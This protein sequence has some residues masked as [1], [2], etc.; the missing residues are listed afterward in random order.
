M[1][2][3]NEVEL[4][5]LSCS[6]KLKSTPCRATRIMLYCLW[7]HIT[8][9]REVYRNDWRV[10]TWGFS[11]RSP[12]PR[13]VYAKALDCQGILT[14]SAEDPNV[15]TT[16][17]P[18]LLPKKM[19]GANREQYYDRQENRRLI[20]DEVIPLDQWPV[21]PS[22]WSSRNLVAHSKLKPNAPSLMYASGRGSN[23]SC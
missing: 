9:S 14:H 11:H 8:S 2:C 10:R 7:Q 4:G 15:I 22:A 19:P 5:P 17:P 13:P 23:P 6:G 12:L 16:G 18:R 20:P 1:T 21:T 3:A